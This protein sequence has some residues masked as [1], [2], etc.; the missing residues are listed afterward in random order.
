[1][2]RGDGRR[3]GNADDVVRTECF[4][5][6]FGDQGGV[7]AAREGDE[8]FFETA[9]V[10]V[11]T[12]AEHEGGVDV[13]EF[14]R[15]GRRCEGK[16]CGA[17]VGHEEIGRESGQAGGDVSL[18]IGYKAATVEDE[19]IVP[20]DGVHIDDGAPQLTGGGGDK[21]FA[22]VALAM[23]PRTGGEVDHQVELSVREPGKGFKMV[24]IARGELRVGPDVLADGDADLETVESEDRRRGGGGFE[25]TVLVEHVVGGQQALAGVADDSALVAERDGIE[26]A[27]AAFGGVGL[28][29]ADQCGDFADFGG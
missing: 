4:D 3:Q 19:F 6:E 24:E 10:R 18:G 7:D 20:A 15:R 5:G 14:G 23:V 9:F 29:C 2:L 1:M 26:K 12:Q 22:H 25:V 13:G 11:I 8:G 17:G 21:L 28:D 16:G 27:A